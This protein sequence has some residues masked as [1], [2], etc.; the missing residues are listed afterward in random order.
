MFALKCGLYSSAACTRISEHKV[1]ILE[2]GGGCGLYTM[3]LINRKIQYFCHICQSA[4]NQPASQPT[5]QS[6]TLS[7]SLLIRQ[8]TSQPH[9]QVLK[10]LLGWVVLSPLE[11][12][13]FILRKWLM[14]RKN[15]LGKDCTSLSKSLTPLLTAVLKRIWVICSSPTSV[16][17]PFTSPCQK[18]GSFPA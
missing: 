14:H 2:G 18:H 8:P 12:I 16:Y 1:F 13:P 10:P 11:N 4:F 6:I 3:W 7:L 5:R 15:Y 17:Q 9:S